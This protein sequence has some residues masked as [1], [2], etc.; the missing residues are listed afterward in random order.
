MRIILLDPIPAEVETTESP[1]NIP[2][3]PSQY[4]YM[5]SIGVQNTSQ[6]LRSD[7]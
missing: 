7:N 6:E 1:R 3:P 5:E 2:A 4:L